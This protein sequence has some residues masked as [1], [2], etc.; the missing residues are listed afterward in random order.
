MARATSPVV[1][2]VMMLGLVIVGAAAVGG[3]V[4]TLETPTE[5]FEATL[6]VSADADRLTLTHRRGPPVAVTDA[7]VTVH[8]DGTPLVH[9]PP[10]PFFTA[11]GFRAGPTGPFN[12]AAS[13]TWRA[14]EETSLQLAATN[15]PLV[16][17]GDVVRVRIATGEQTVAARATA[18]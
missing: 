2:V 3:A 14:G 8:I 18:A 6:S 9:Q 4:T 17:P 12:S 11:K 7:S 1:A 13:D 16:A 10:V 5:P 15:A